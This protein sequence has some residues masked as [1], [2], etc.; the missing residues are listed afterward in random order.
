MAKRIG[1][2][3]FRETESEIGGFI[4]GAL[5]SAAG[6]WILYSRYGINHQ[7]V[8]PDALTADRESSVSTRVGMVSYYVDRKAPEG[9]RPLVLIHSV[10][11]A[12]SSYEVKPLFNAFRGSRPVFAIDLPGFGFSERSKRIYSS[13]LYQDTIL[14][15]LAGIV[16]GPADVVALSLCG[17][18]AARAAQVRPDLFHSL[19]MISPTGLSGSTMNRRSNRPG[20]IS[21]GNLVHP[22]L[23]FR[24]WALPL[25]DAISTRTSIEYF[26]QKSF[27]GHITPGFIEYAYASAH[28]SGAE[29]APLYFLTGKLFTPHVCERV[30]EQLRIPVL[31]L[32]DQDAYTSFDALPDLLLKNPN[33]QAIRL[34]PNKGLPQF[35]RTA[36]TVE[37]LEGFWQGIK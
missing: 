3:S 29:Y 20:N 23:S 28:Q 9:T 21:L 27:V 12:A 31:A 26:L 19:S 14:E 25:F 18:F 6:G 34:V 7:V 1:D 37:V 5:L 24:L 16:G 36:D 15:F 17:E 33:W 4:V 30:Y 2:R 8:L 32:Y 35:E 10:N 13:Q 11:A 22:F